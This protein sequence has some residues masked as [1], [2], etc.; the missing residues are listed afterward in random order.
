MDFEN[1]KSNV[2][3]M[4]KD[5]GDIEFLLYIIK[6]ND[7]QEYY[8][9][10]ELLE[11]FY[12]LGMIDYLCKENNLPFIENYNYIR[13]YKLEEPVFPL[14]IHAKCLV[15]K[16]EEPKNKSLREAIP[17]FKRFNI[18]ENGVRDAC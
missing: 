14:G 5:M 18:I 10:E 7:I 15:F 6:S 1:F 11:C 4:L 2:C 9:K 13:K 3:H 17:E 12:L 8:E 16:S